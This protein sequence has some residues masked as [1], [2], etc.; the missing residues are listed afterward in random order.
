MLLRDPWLA[1]ASAILLFLS[2]APRAGAQDLPP[3][4]DRDVVVGVCTGCH[5]VDTF[6]SFHMNKDG[7]VLM[8][9]DM[10]FRGADGTD[11]QLNAVADYLATY[12]GKQTNVNTASVKELESDLSFSPKDAA[13]IVKWRT[14]KGPFHKLADLKKVPGVDAARIDQQ[15]ANIIF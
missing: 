10:V 3:G 8:I 5:T 1:G 4:K 12:F 6:T 13:A 11:E 9:R 14:G 7:W 2:V 15:K